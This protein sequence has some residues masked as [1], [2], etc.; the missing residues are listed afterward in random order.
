MPAKLGCLPNLI[1]ELAGG[2]LTTD[3]WLVFATIVVPLAAS[4][5]SVIGNHTPLNRNHVD[6]SS[7]ARLH[8]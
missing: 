5:Y 3:Q 7:L 6:T 2:S 8:G 1:G 4:Q